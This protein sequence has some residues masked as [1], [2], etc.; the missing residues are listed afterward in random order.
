MSAMSLCSTSRV[1]VQGQS[2]HASLRATSARMA[3]SS[4]KALRMRSARTVTRK[5]AAKFV[6]KAEADDGGIEQRKPQLASADREKFA[7][8]GSGQHECRSCSYIY[9]QSKGDPEFPVAAGTTFEV[10]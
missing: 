9:D 3:G 2:K 4:V 10:R 8:I 5:N 7:V 1:I 6:T